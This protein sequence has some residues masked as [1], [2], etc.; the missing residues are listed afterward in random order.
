MR[1][2]LKLKLK[3]KVLVQSGIRTHGIG[4]IKKNQ[5]SNMAREQKNYTEKAKGIITAKLE[6]IVVQKDGIS[7]LIEKVSKIKGDVKT[8]QNRL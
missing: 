3:L 6:N 2:W 5:Q 7:V 4:N 1:K 8:I